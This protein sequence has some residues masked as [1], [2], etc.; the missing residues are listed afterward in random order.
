MLRLVVH[1]LSAKR[2]S[3]SHHGELA[4]PLAYVTHEAYMEIYDAQRVRGVLAAQADDA[5]IHL[6]TQMCTGLVRD[7]HTCSSSWHGSC[8]RVRSMLRTLTAAVSSAG[9][10]PAQHVLQDT[11]LVHHADVPSMRLVR[12]MYD[13]HSVVSSKYQLNNCS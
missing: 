13:T 6:I 2:R 9:H 12:R 4:K 11:G 3:R 8:T 10:R 1:S 7:D 5:E